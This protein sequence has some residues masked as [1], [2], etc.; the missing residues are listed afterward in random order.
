MA[1]PSYSFAELRE[2]RGCARHESA[3]FRASF[4]GQPRFSVG[5]PILDE[6]DWPVCVG[7][8][9][10]LEWR[11]YPVPHAMKTWDFGRWIAEAPPAKP[12]A[13]VE[14]AEFLDD[15]GLNPIWIWWEYW[16][17]NRTLADIAGAIGCSVG[18]LQGRMM[19]WQFPRRS[20]GTGGRGEAERSKLTDAQIRDLKKRVVE[21]ESKTALAEE[22]GIS[23]QRVHQIANGQHRRLVE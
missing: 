13:A 3:P 21:K 4:R 8:A 5:I 12:K 14:P 16:I 18:A 23:R 15:G 7:G 17:R 6:E 1:K 22:F 2:F 20:Q 9:L 19:K 11:A 10:K